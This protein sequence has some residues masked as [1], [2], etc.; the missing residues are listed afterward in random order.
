MQSRADGPGGLTQHHLADLRRSGL[1]DETIAAAGLYSLSAA[2]AQALLER[3]DV[4]PGMAIPYAGCTFRTGTPYVRVRLDVPL[5]IRGHPARYLTKRGERNR[6]YVPPMVS[7]SILSDPT[8]PL[9]VTEGEKKALK[10]CQEGILC[11]ALAGVWCWK[12][13]VPDGR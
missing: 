9:V 6:L 11:I 1:T 7:L 13:R 5:L 2:E 3:D 8:I 10:A 4:G 12:T